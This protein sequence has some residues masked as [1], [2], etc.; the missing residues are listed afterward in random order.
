MALSAHLYALFSVQFLFV[1]GLRA[2]LSRKGSL[3]RFVPGFRT[4]GDLWAQ[5]LLTLQALSYILLIALKDF[6]LLLS[7]SAV[8]HILF[9]LFY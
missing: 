7:S 1:M 5:L 4:P 6:P 2:H 8:Y 3:L 9:V